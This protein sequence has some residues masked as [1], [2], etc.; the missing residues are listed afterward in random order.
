MQLN[1]IMQPAWSSLHDGSQ[2]TYKKGSS[3]TAGWQDGIQQQLFKV[4]SVALVWLC[5]CS[6][7]KAATAGD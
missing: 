2:Q 1:C 7:Y 5:V 6:K 4:H 3:T